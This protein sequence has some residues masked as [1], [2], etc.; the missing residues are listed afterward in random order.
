MS[1][2]YIYLLLFFCVVLTPLGLIAQGGA[3]GEWS[4]QE[5]QNMLGFVPKSIA[6]AKPFVH[7][8]FPDYEMRGV[9]LLASTWLS[10]L[11]GVA[12][13][14]LVFFLLKRSVKNAD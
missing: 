8:L 13:V 3:W 12:L 5:L 11:V 1:K 4:A 9:N 6:E 7:I 14:F 10:A 2:K